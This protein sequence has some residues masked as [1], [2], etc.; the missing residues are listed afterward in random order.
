MN[1]SQFGRLVLMGVLTLGAGSTRIAATADDQ[2]RGHGQDKGQ[3]VTVSFGAGLNSAAAANHHVLPRTIEVDKGG[4]V[5][6]AVSGFHQIFVYQPGVTPD[7]V[8]AAAAPFPPVGRPPTPQELYI[9][10]GLP[11]DPANPILMYVGLNPG[12]PPNPPLNPL[13]PPNA[14]MFSAAFNRVE[15]V[16]FQER[17]RYLVICNINPHFR[18]GMYAWVTVK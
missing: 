8:L 13:Q 3:S 6:F 7:D 5:N 11:L 15:S 17:G 4:V 18:D 10:Y 9:N 12:F 2:H 16:V 14:P 1:R